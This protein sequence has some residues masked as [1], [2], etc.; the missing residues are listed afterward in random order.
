ME[1]LLGFRK[2]SRPMCSYVSLVALLL[3]LTIEA[4]IRA[5][6]FEQCNSFTTIL[7]Y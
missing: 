1:Q 6:D 5:E 4:I 7:K 2:M 3:S